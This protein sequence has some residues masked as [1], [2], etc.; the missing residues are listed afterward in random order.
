MPVRV[1]FEATAHLTCSPRT[2]AGNENRACLLSSLSA[3]LQ[4]LMLLLIASAAIAQ[5]PVPPLTAPVIDQT[6][7]LAPEQIAALDRKLRAFHERKGSQ[8]SVLIVPTTQPETIEQYAIRVAESW[9]LG[10]RD[11]DDGVLLLIARDDRTV[12]IEV[13]YGLEGALPDVLANRII[14]QVI[15]PRFRQGDFGG[16]VV[17]GV[18]RIIGVIEGEPLP[19]PQRRTQ[20]SA[21]GI[22]SFLPLLLMLVFVGGGILRRMFGAFG[23]ATAV[24][25]IAGVLAWLLTSVMGIAI[26][27]GL[28]AF[29]FTLVGGGGFGGGGWSSG[30]RGGSGGWGSRGGGGGFGGGGWSGGGGGFGGGGASGRW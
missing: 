29:I 24:G 8:V 28:M 16:G 30:P 17:E 23:G 26:G 20:P 10:R 3:T 22:G 13:G 4:A 18:D 7:T 5:V 1:A 21:E 9:K 2:G 15:V 12:R 19:E 6:Q 25:G 14:D 11:V 27:A